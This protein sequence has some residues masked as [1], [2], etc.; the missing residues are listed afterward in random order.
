[1]ISQLVPKR[2]MVTNRRTSR[3][4]RSSTRSSGRIKCQSSRIWVRISLTVNSSSSSSIYCS[5]KQLI[6]ACQLMHHLRPALTTGTRLTA[7]SAST[8]S[9]SSSF[10]LAAPW[11]HWLRAR[12]PPRP[13]PSSAWLSAHLA[14]NS[15]HFS[16]RASSNQFQA[17]S[18]LM[19]NSTNKTRLT[20]RPIR[21]STNLKKRSRLLQHPCSNRTQTSQLQ[22]LSAVTSA[23]TKNRMTSVSR[24]PR[25][26]RE[27]ALSRKT[28]RWLGTR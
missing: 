24:G 23:P 21:C 8:I 7:W 5:M 9:S 13:R 19:Y 12:R 18:A 25:S 28:S 3:S 22:W 16:T 17:R 27:S 11:K 15:S 10:W 20:F 6:Y 4:W 1:M 26:R 14:L 2:Q